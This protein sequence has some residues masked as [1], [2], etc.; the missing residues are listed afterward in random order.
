MKAHIDVDK[1]EDMQAANEQTVQW[2]V[3]KRRKTSEK[4]PP[5]PI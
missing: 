3:A 1:R 4:L 2:H 5:V